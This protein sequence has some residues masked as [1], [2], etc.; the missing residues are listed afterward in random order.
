MAVRSIDRLHQAED[1]A[2]KR[3]LVRV[4]FNVPL[5]HGRVD[6]DARIRAALPTLRLLVQ[7]GA[8][9][10]L[11]SHLGRPGG[12]P[13]PAYSLEPVAAHL[14]LLMDRNVSFEADCTGAS[15][16]E[17]PGSLEAGQLV[18]LEN[19][20]FHPGEKANDERF[21]DSLAGLADCYVNDAFATLHRAHASTVGLARRLPAAAGLLVERELAA[22]GR[23]T[24]EPARPYVAL[25]GG[26]KVSD[27]LPA[28]QKLLER[29]DRV[30]VGGPVATTFLAASGVDVADSAMEPEY[31]SLARKILRDAGDRLGLPADVVIA[32]RSDEDAETRGME[33]R[34]VDP[35]WQ[36]L[37]IGPR[38]R[39]E[40]A[41]E[42]KEAGTVAWAGPLGLF[43]CAPFSH[44]TFEVARALA[45]AEG[46]RIVGGGET[47]M[48]VRQAGVAEQID[49]VSTGGGAAL[50]FLCGD[51]L[52]GL[53]ALE[54]A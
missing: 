40:F 13:D 33:A 1:L 20:R 47:A 25:I 22:L 26:A 49:H 50:A 9:L 28:V 21:A 4:D 46:F 3:V 30:L 19:T 35:G 16:Q 34:D 42:L 8:A 27:K 7:R 45:G 10:I 41:A 11:L 6:D 53:A 17:R 5:N 51:T 2:G 14:Q 18:M 23:A 15:L 12:R 43:E 54:A 39:A 48:A 44:G 31:V 24:I 29:A 52:P 32:S 37:D 36:I 38:T